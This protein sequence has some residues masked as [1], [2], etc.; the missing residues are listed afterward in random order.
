MEWMLKRFN[1][2]T[3]DELYAI[4]QL[5]SEVFVVEQNCIYHDPDGKDQYAWHLM[6]FEDDKLV[7][8]T[9]LF[10]AGGTYPDPSIGRVVTSP[11][12]RRAGL[13]REVMVRSIEHCEEL[14]G[15]TSIT[16]GA[17]LYLRKF[18]ES[19]G[20]IASGEEYIEDGIP[21]VTMTRK[22]TA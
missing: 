21:H 18:Y 20:F 14:F 12:K 9:R 17:Q 6:G 3:V 16:L 4:L 10:A 8:Y 22:C 11:S 2:L 19:L 15:K 1:E 5:R 7:A 13:G